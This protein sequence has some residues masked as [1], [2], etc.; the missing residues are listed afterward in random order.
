MAKKTAKTAEEI[1]TELANAAAPKPIVEFAGMDAISI[2]SIMH[3]RRQHVSLNNYKDQGFNL[4]VGMTRIDNVW[5]RTVIDRD[6]FVAE[7]PG[8]SIVLVGRQWTVPCRVHSKNSEGE[9]TSVETEITLTYL[10]HDPAVFKTMKHYV[11]ISS[12]FNNFKNIRGFGW[13]VGCIQKEKF[14]LAS[15][16]YVKCFKG[17]EISWAS[18]NDDGF[19]DVCFRKTSDSSSPELDF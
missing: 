9:N 7:S 13:L 16:D 3:S 18:M 10:D 17:E 8:H 1:T 5:K 19:F 12:R 15:K 4:L 2:C 11:P 6:L 14:L